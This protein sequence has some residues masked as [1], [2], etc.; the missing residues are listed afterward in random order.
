MVHCNRMQRKLLLISLFFLISN[1]YVFAQQSVLSSRVCTVSALIAYLQ[2]QNSFENDLVIIDSVY[3]FT[4]QLCDS[5]YQ[6]VLLTLTFSFLPYNS[7][8]LVTPFLKNTFDIPVYSAPYDLFMQKNAKSPRYLYYDTPDNAYGDLD[9]PSHFFGS[10]LLSYSLKNYY[11]SM[12]IGYFVEI[13]ESTF[14]VEGAADPRDIATNQ[15]GIAFGK[16][17][18][19]NHTLLPSNII[20]L[21]NAS[22]FLR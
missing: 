17:L 4:V 14:L 10:A 16:E 5:N 18:S 21:Y 6:E 19:K 20:R 22:I 13:F 1:T 7:V 11:V 15:L 9:K 12:S 8:P 3:R 2:K